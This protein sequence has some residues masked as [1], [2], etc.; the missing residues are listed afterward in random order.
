MDDPAV[1]QIDVPPKSNHRTNG[2]GDWR[3][4]SNSKPSFKA[5]KSP[6]WKTDYDE[7]SHLSISLS[8][9]SVS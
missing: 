7:R 5:P 6:L 2:Q 1:G 3:A 8:A 9:K 4:Y